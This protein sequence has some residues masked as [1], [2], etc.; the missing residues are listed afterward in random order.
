MQGEEENR[1]TLQYSIRMQDLP[2]EIGRLIE[3]PAST[4]LDK[5]N[6]K[7]RKL[8]AYEEENFLSEPF[9]D[10]IHMLRLMLANLDASLRDVDNIVSGYFSMME[11]AQEPPEMAPAM[12]LLPPTTEGI[13]TLS[14]ATEELSKKLKLFKEKEGAKN[15]EESSADTS[16]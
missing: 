16:E 10:D 5:V 12:E 11:E 7:T 9:R 6:K 14:D 2:E 1:A 15:A 13:E 8:L 4:Q 3:G